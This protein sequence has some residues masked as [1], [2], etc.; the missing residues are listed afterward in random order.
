MTPD[1]TIRSCAARILAERPALPPGVVAA[2]QTEP[3]VVGLDTLRQYA[4]AHPG[5]ADAAAIYGQ[6]SRAWRD[7][8]LRVA[9]RR[10]R[11][12]PTAEAAGAK[13]IPTAAGL[14]A[15]P[16][17][18]DVADLISALSAVGY[19]AV[20]LCRAA[21]GAVPPQAVSAARRPGGPRLSLP[22]WRLLRAIACRAD[23]KA[24]DTA[25]VPRGRRAGT[26]AA[27]LQAGRPAWSSADLAR[28]LGIPRHRAA[29]LVMGRSRPT[30]AESALL[31]LLTTHPDGLPLP[32]AP[33]ESIEAAGLL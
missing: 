25:G 24:L 4:E 1:E 13:P 12:R 18:S 14:I 15:R 27:H 32:P 31:A 5:D 28:E 11:G 2:L 16:T 21:G 19:T 8:S 29:A 10:G 33:L 9:R 20:W 30:A 3:P 17:S 6:I 26:V 22:A 23:R 7:A